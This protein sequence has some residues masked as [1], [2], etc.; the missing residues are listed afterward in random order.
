[1]SKHWT[2]PRLHGASMQEARTCTVAGGAGC[3]N[4]Q[5]GGQQRGQPLGRHCQLAPVAL[6]RVVA[7]QVVAEAEARRRILF[8]QHAWPAGEAALSPCTCYNSQY[9]DT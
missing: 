2:C 1:M 8:R 6:L 4:R 3:L 5:P 9:V 7:A